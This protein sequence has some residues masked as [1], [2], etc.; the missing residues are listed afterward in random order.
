MKANLI[1][2]INEVTMRDYTIIEEEGLNTLVRGSA[3]MGN[4]GLTLSYKDDEE[5]PGKHMIVI[6]APD[7]A[8]IFKFMDQAEIAVYILT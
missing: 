3:A 4:P 2:H 1:T 8:G 5:N 6:A 7:L